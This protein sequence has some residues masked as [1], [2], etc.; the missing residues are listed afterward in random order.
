MRRD[1]PALHKVDTYNYGDRISNVSSFRLLL[2]AE[3]PFFYF[4]IINSPV[5]NLVC[6]LFSHST[7]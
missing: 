4:L 7:S 3:E 1:L 5:E 2:L 6:L